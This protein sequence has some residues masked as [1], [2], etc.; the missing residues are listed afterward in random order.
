MMGWSRALSW[1]S[2]R[3]DAE[4]HQR[5]ILRNELS[6]EFVLSTASGRP[7]WNRTTLLSPGAR[8]SNSCALP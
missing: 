2:A 7:R 5:P 3:S 4:E 8:G 6:A 1:I